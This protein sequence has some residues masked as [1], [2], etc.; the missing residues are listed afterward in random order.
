MRFA[1]LAL[2]VLKHERARPVQD[3]DP[4]TDD[5]GGM[6]AAGDPFPTRLDSDELHVRIVDERAEDAD[7]V[8]PAA[9]AGDDNVGKP[10][11][12]REAL[13]AR[14]AADHGLEVTDHR[15]IR[16]RTDRGTE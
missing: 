16:M 4:S 14:F 6:L 5:R 10:S 11:E 2:V 1:D 15:R 3:A 8:R 7:R 12:L 9:D 13:L